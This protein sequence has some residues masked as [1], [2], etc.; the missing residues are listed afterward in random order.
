[1]ECSPHTILIYFCCCCCYYSTMNINERF[2][3]FV[4]FFC[5]HRARL[6]CSRCV[7][8]NICYA[9]YNRS[10]IWL[11]STPGRIH[12]S[13]FF[14]RVSLL[15]IGKARDKMRYNT[16]S[17]SHAKTISLV[18]TEPKNER[19][20]VREKKQHYLLRSMHA[21]TKAAMMGRLLRE[22]KKVKPFMKLKK[23]ESTLAPQCKMIPV[24]S[25]LV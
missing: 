23:N 13:L 10:R 2:L 16:H 3:F 25:Y 18:G 7:L 8:L 24:A 1:M 14:I 11:S 4:L 5:V 6:R 19:Q 21:F 20:R 17:S 15:Y 12:C 9:W 22:G